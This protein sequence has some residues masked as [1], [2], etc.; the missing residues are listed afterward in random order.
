[1]AGQK[2][3]PTDSPDGPPTENLYGRRAALGRLATV[4][5]GTAVAPNVAL[6]T[7]EA[8]PAPAPTPVRPP[9]D[10][11][12]RNPVVQW[13]K[14]LTQDE[15][16]TVAALCDVILPADARS[17]AA[18]K[19]GVPGF[20]D[21]WVSAPYPL[22]EADRL[23]VRGG[24]VWLDTES[25][26]RFGRAF[27]ALAAPEKRSICDDVCDLARVRSEWR[28]GALLFDKVRALSLVGFYTTLEGMKDLEYVGN[29]PS[30]TFEG[31][32]RQA[33]VH[34]KLAGRDP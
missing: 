34:L 28:P 11:D 7:A 13:Q 26:R 21:E 32:P 22:Q 2:A 15:L 9:L 30:A 33:L 31:P 1:M 18:S 23:I 19:V 4:A 5:T 25:R 29:V 17:P 12:L 14:V 8:A 10:Q 6:A 27:V 3:P 24:L 16:R 20:I